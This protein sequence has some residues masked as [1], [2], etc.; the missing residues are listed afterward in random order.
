MRAR[1]GGILAF[2]SILTG[3]VGA[4]KTAGV[5]AVY[6]AIDSAG[7][8][9]RDIFFTDS[10]AIYCIAKVSSATQ[11]ATIDF[12]VLQTAVYPWCSA[13]ANP[14]VP[15]SQKTYIQPVFAVGE[16]TPGVGVENV[17]AGS[18][19]SSGV[20]IQTNCV[21]YCAMNLPSTTLCDHADGGG[22]AAEVAAS[23]EDGYNSLGANSCGMGLTCCE[24]KNPTTGSTAS[25]SAATAVPYPA[26]QY[27]CV[28]YLNG[29][30]VGETSFTIEYPAGNEDPSLGGAGCG[31]V[32][33]SSC[34]CP[35]PPPVD[36]IPCYGW[37][38]EG[39][40][41]PGYVGGTTCKCMPTGNWS[42]LL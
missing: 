25:S 22:S 35:V 10:S 12:T 28:V 32:P 33:S 19:L 8:Q 26:G 11:D 7:A 34:Y 13:L 30:D 24:P 38:P 2:A 29:V 31:N 21:G 1:L 37:V 16:E 5:S 40:E 4:C 39:A 6:M 18:L 27:I 17:V 23:C 42:C 41:C 15:E 14:G 3:A 9:R 20:T 36:G